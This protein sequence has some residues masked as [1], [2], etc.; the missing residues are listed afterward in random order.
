L[1]RSCKNTWNPWINQFLTVSAQIRYLSTHHVLISTQ[2]R[3]P[4]LSHSQVDPITQ[5]VDLGR[6]NSGVRIRTQICKCPTDHSRLTRLVQLLLLQFWPWSQLIDSLG[7]VVYITIMHS[8][9]LHGALPLGRCEVVCKLPAGV[10]MRI[11]GQTLAQ[12]EGL[13]TMRT[14]YTRFTRIALHRAER[15]IVIEFV[16]AAEFWCYDFLGFGWFVSER[17]CQRIFWVV[18]FSDSVIVIVFLFVI[19]ILMQHIVLSSLGALYIL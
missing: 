1:T 9:E 19:G 4:L 5:V 18:V 12:L 11:P 17:V 13:Y 6:F 15:V 8:H 7:H 10:P 3:F 16:D 2:S 14:G